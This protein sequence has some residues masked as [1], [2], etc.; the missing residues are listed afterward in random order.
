[1]GGGAHPLTLPLTVFSILL[2]LHSLPSHSP[3]LTQGRDFSRSLSDSLSLLPSNQF[4][5]FCLSTHPHTGA[6]LAHYPLHMWIGSDF[7]GAGD[8]R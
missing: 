8:D 1:M 4:I 7:V 6:H 3:S 5:Y 2:Y